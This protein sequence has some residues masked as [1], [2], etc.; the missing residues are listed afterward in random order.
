MASKEEFSQLSLYVYDINPDAN[1]D[2]RPLEPPGWERLEYHSDRLDGFSYGVFRRIGTTEVVVAYAG[3]N[4][5]IDWIANVK[6]GIGLS[7]TQTTA[8]AL[9]YLD[10][11][12]KYGS[13]ISL[14]GHSLGGGLAS[15]MAVWFDR[16]ATVFDEAP[17]QLTAQNWAFIAITKAALAI[18]GYSDPA[19]TSY[20]GTLDFW[21]REA[22]VTNYY[23]EGEALAILRVLPGVV[24]MGQDNIVRANIADMNGVGGAI[25]LHSQAL[26]T[27]TLMSEAF[28]QSTYAS[29]R[30]IPLLMEESLYAYDAKTSDQQNV[31]INFIRSEQGT[32]RKL[33]HFAADLQKLGVNISSLNKAGQDALIAQAIEWYYWQAAGYAGTEFFAQNGELLQYATATGDGLAGAQNKAVAYVEKWLAPIV[34]GHGESYSSRFANYQQWN[35]AA[36]SGGV[37][38][39]ARDVSKSQIFIGGGGAD[40][41]TGGQLAD[42]MFAGDGADTLDGADGDDQLF[43]GI[44]DDQLRGGNGY[45]RYVIEG[46]DTIEDSDG[47]G[48][49]RDKSGRVLAGL[50]EKRS[51][52]SYVYQTDPNVTVTGGTDLTLTLADGSSVTIKGYQD[53][54]LGFRI[55]DTAADTPA[56]NPNAD[57][58]IVGD[59]GPKDFY[60]SDGNLYYEY[61]DIGNLI[62]DP[63]KA[64]P[65]DDTL[66][67]GGGNDLVNAGA[68]ND[69][70]WKTR[71]GD[72]TINL[73]TGD[74]N[75]YTTFGASGRVI[76]NGG[77]GRDY[78]GAGNGR[79]IIEGGADADGIYGSSENDFLYGDTRGVAADFIA[80]GATQQASGQQGEWFD[81]EDGDDQVFGGAGSDLVACGAGDDLIVTGGGNDYIWGDWNT[82]SPGGEWKSWSVAESVTIGADG[83]KTYNY[84]VANI[85]SESNA[86]VGNDVIHAGAGNDFA[87][88]E[89]GDDT[90]YLEDGD[91]KSW[92]GEGNDVILGGAGADLISG[93][94]GKDIVP[95]SLHGY[96]FLDG[97]DGNDELFGGGAADILLGGAGDDILSG[98]DEIENAGDD[99]LDG[100]DG[101]DTLYGGAGADI[102]YGGTG[103]DQLYGMEGDD[104]LD[105]E[106]GDD[107]LVGGEGG[108]RLYGGV[109]N[110]FLQGDAGTDSGDGDDMLDGGAGDDTLL[111]LGGNDSIYSGAGADAVDAGGG[112]DFVFAGDDNDLVDG[113]A[114]NDGLY[115][116][117]GNDQLQ[118]GTDDDTLAG[119]EG[120]DTLFGQDGQDTINGDDGND[121]II[122]GRGDDSLDGGTGDDVYVYYLGDG[123]DRIADAG[124]TDWLLLPEVWW[125]SLKL[126]TG[127]LKLTLPDGGEIHLD[128]FDPDNPYAAGGIEYFQF[129]DGT[130]MSKTQLIN[131]LGIAPIGTPEADVLSGTAL[132]ETIQALA[133]DDVVSARAGND[134]VDAGDGND[135]VYGDDG[136]DTL[137]GG[138]GDDVLLGEGGNDTL[139]GEAGNDLLSG[140]AGSDSLQG[141]DG[142]D[143]YLFQLGDGQDIVTDTLGQN[144]VALGEGLTLDSIRL[145]REGN[146]LWVSSRTTTDRLTVK[147]WFAADSHFAT[148]TLGDGT[149][150][151]QAGVEAALPQNQAP[152][153]NP[154]AVIVAEDGTLAASGNA[155]ANDS[156]LDGQALRVTNPGSYAGNYGN[157]N[158]QFDGTYTYSLANGS[159]AV[160]SLA[161][162]QSATE[163]FAYAIT[164]DDLNAAASATST[165]T[166]TVN[167]TNDAPIAGSDFD[168]AYEDASWVQTGN[169]LANDTD[170]DAG[171]VL[172]LADPGPRVGTY[173]TLTFGANGDYSY[174]LANDSIAVQSLGEGQSVTESFA[175]A[176]SDGIAQTSGNLTIETYGRNDAP[177]VAAPLAD[178]SATIGANWNWQL[179]IDSFTDVDA[180]DTLSYSAML[181]DGS[182]LPAWLVFDPAT[183]T[184]SGQVPANATGTLDIQVTVMDDFGNSE[185]SSEASDVFTLTFAAGSGGNGGCGH[186]NEGVGNGEDPPPPGHDHN[187]NDGPGTWPGHPGSQHGQGRDDRDHNHDDG[188]KDHGRDKGRNYFDPSVL[189]DYCTSSDRQHDQGSH[190]NRDE[191]QTFARWLA[192]EQAVS[193]LA[194]EANRGVACLDTARGADIGGLGRATG[195]LHGGRQS[196]GDDTIS[197]LPGA[198][199]KGFT[200][201]QE[202]MRNLG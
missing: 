48:T 52:G 44:G 202:G 192:A 127:S 80:Q 109:G 59:F 158:L 93:D 28:R 197:L 133:G 87:N 8:A 26:L 102:L 84:D 89:R 71:G 148:L 33:T 162:G 169:V 66:Y 168:W 16:P 15:V 54:N 11:K 161:A 51:D 129:A 178:Q 188:A 18:A 68:G 65:R 36:G 193:R 104:T 99:Y 183:R 106:D 35:I 153:A 50:I 9:A 186:G 77:D 163:S 103:A 23:L 117:L 31:L 43:G 182:D 122:G 177:I 195:G 134:S 13:N 167:G 184:F 181:A 74:D 91:D 174:E 96:D 49:I 114:G 105:G 151:D 45:D 95:L 146:D 111:G 38:A 67:E 166:V 86:G 108:D 136:N 4:S 5:G 22:Q 41:F 62:T 76:A 145:S 57:R 139:L 171:A 29:T 42:A 53:G 115:G 113:G 12:Q 156:D 97:G 73:G 40:T 75:L 141:G 132:A 92:G 98:D 32:G 144:A 157:L 187:W 79:D 200:G 116:G 173:G 152:T 14:T 176:V 140:G 24:V 20:T 170:I 94:N 189:A 172:T 149:V 46:H 60:D 175:Y 126:G 101:N 135:V 142:D 199:L 159:S 82:W 124:G 121:Y 56:V 78:L 17:F 137:H 130:V 10:A 201:L 70:V 123:M 143:S 128:D 7:S 150:L 179:P 154:D 21:T 34:T 19:F 160:Q 27:A 2:N 147:D 119:N 185:V 196:R 180:G 39:A 37:T 118:G 25:D 198:G 55:V 194:S 81:A 110:D 30:V 3:T 58:V 83:G 164:D 85:Y 190:A 69:T 165:I 138:A 155:L 90:I 64:G 6:N 125:Q 47:R 63:A 107:T 120:N 88:G 112:D 100:Q 61:D 72:D 131:A 1:Q 191:A